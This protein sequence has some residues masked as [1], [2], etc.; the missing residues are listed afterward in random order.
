M[1][2]A[3]GSGRGQSHERRPPRHSASPRTIVA[4]NQVSPSASAVWSRSTTSISR[5][6]GVR[7]RSHRSERRRQDDHLQHDRRDLPADRGRDRLRGQRYPLVRMARMAAKASFCARIRSRARGISRTFQNIR[8]FA[9]MTAL[10]N[11]LIGMHS[12]LKSTP[13]GAVLRLPSVKIERARG[14]R[15]GPRAARLCLACAARGR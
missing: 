5:S 2:R 8:L 1:S 3:A 14:P 11:V 4:Q 15:Q 7:S 10:E 13:L 9:N 12:R 6:R